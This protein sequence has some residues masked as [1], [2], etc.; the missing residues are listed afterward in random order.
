MPGVPDEEQSLFAALD[1]FSA[2][3]DR[4]QPPE[5][6]PVDELADAPAEP[7]RISEA[8]AAAI[9]VQARMGR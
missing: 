4:W 7:W 2:A 8:V 5:S 9:Y 3:C 1:H 6:K